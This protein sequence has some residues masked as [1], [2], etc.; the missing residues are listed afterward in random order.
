MPVKHVFEYAVVRVVPKVEREEFLNMGVIL[1]CKDKKFLDCILSEDFSCLE[2]M[3]PKLDLEEV[4]EHLHSIKLI[5][6]GGKDA[7]AIGELDVP[8]RFRW[9]TATRSTIIQASKV[10]PGL[11]INPAETLQRLYGQLILR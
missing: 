8:S 7:G 1:Y 5:C 4:N 11:C 2:V 9:I 3:F 6:T 10:H